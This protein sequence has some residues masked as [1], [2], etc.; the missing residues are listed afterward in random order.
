MDAPADTERMTGSA[1]RAVDVDLA[2]IDGHPDNANKMPEQRYRKLRA[3]IEETRRY[4]PLIVR[5]HPD[6][7]QRLQLLD[8]HYRTRALRELGHKR[9]SVCIWDVDDNEARI[10]LLTLNALS[11]EDEPAKRARLLQQ[12]RAGMSMDQIAAAL[13]EDKRQLQRLVEATQPPQVIHAPPDPDSVPVSRVFRL[14][15]AHAERLDR[16]LAPIDNDPSR[17]LIALLGLAEAEPEPSAEA[18]SEPGVV[19]P[20][21]SP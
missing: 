9:A 11:G 6:D 18:Q 3:R 13:P 5:P 15:P 8:G 14:L 21:A 4:P 20:A 7:P 17:A 10:L 16:M 12:V 2:T 1:L 19:S